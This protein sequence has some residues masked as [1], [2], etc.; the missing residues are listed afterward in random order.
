MNHRTGDQCILTFKP[1]GW[2]GKDAYDISGKVI[3]QRGRVAYEIAGRWNSQ[4]V[5]KAVGVGGVWK[6]GLACSF[7][8][9]QIMISKPK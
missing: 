1:R 9:L 8:R 6:A 7:F 3:D 4:L 5:A 2:R